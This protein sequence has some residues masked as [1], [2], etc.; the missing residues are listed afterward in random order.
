MISRFPA[1]GQVVRVLSYPYRA[2]KIIGSIPRKNYCTYPSEEE[3]RRA[4][5]FMNEKFNHR[6]FIETGT[7]KGKTLEY[8][9]QYFAVLYSIELDDDLYAKA[10]EKF[11]GDAA[12]TLLHGNSGEM[13]G[14]VLA[15]LNE[16]AFFWLDAHYSKG[17]TARGKKDSP[18][19]EELEAIFAHPI[20]DHTIFID[21]ARYFIG[22][23]GYPTIGRL[24]KLVK[25]KLPTHRLFIFDDAIRIYRP[26]M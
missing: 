5:A 13:L 16:P 26:D 1:L 4:I 17:V 15:E 6:V 25:T 24:Q 8:M 20:K 19:I 2:A 21:D 9:R 3:K 14:Y 7:Y 18:I 22:V 11:E 12:V 23:D 10:A